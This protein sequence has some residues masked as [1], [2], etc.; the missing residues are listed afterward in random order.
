M[1][2]QTITMEQFEDLIKLKA[3]VHALQCYVDAEKYPDKKIMCNIVGVKY[4]EE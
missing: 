4:E 2:G 1:E 3:A